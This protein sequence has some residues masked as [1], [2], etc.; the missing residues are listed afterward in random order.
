M[1]SP[2]GR[3]YRA[4]PANP[5][6]TY[7][8]HLR[9]YSPCSRHTQPLLQVPMYSRRERRR[10]TH[11][12]YKLVYPSCNHTLAPWAVVTTMRGPMN[13]KGGPDSQ[14]LCPLIAPLIRD[15]S[16]NLSSKSIHCFGSDVVQS[17]SQYKPSLCRFVD[18]S[19]LLSGYYEVP[20]VAPLPAMHVQ[21]KTRASGAQS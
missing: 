16:C 3:I 2:F 4:R 11:L 19:L 20:S 21:P 13:P 14:P 17:G 9:S 15:L 1:P 6:A 8:Q 18:I 12:Q 7:L 5:Q 10:K